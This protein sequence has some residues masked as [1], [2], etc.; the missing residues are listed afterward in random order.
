VREAVDDGEDKTAE[1]TGD[2]DYFSVK[3]EGGR[4]SHKFFGGTNA[5]TRS[6]NLFALSERSGKCGKGGG[7][8]CCIA[9][10]PNLGS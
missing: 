9:A 8:A 2:E 3:T 10:T 5:E 7:G 4:S 1:A 6:R